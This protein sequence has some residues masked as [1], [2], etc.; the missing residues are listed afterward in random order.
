MREGLRRAEAGDLELLRMMS[1]ELAQWFPQHAQS[2]DAGLA[3]HLRSVG[4]DPR[5]GAV[6]RPDAL[7]AS[8]ISGCGSVACT[9]HG[10]GAQESRQSASA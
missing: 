2:M 8:E 4:H 10:E 1:A 3:L 6:A 9:P 5:T 7:P